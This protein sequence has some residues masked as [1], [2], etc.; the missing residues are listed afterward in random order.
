MT[1]ELG[2]GERL[3]LAMGEVKG[4][5]V[6]HGLKLEAIQQQ[7]TKTNGR[8]TTLED[9]ADAH[10]QCHRD[11]VQFQAG[12]SKRR[13]DDMDMIET[14]FEWGDKLLLLAVG[15]VLGISADVMAGMG[16]SGGVWEGVAAAVLTFGAIGKVI[17]G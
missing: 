6:A 2:M 4:E 15:L 5:L 1:D 3:L 11:M 17:A 13:E 7:T 14:A 10:E 8:V 9:R 12:Y 16:I